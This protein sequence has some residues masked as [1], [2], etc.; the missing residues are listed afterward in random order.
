VQ[1]TRGGALAPAATARDRAR[2]KA[3]FG[4]FLILAVFFTILL[5]VITIRSVSSE[6]S[7]YVSHDSINRCLLF[8]CVI[9]QICN[10]FWI[11][12]EQQRNTASRAHKSRTTRTDQ[13]SN[14][15][16]L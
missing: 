15:G 3:L 2:L 14:N 5:I 16:L 8:Q 1:S 11:G 9:Q 12:T 4:F 6:T 13:R 7:W 10:V